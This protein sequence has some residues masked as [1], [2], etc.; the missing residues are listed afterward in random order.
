MDLLECLHEMAAVLFFFFSLL[1]LILKSQQVRWKSG[2]VL[3]LSSEAL[4]CFHSG[5]FIE[6]S[7]HSRG[8]KWGS[9]FSREKYERI[10]EDILIPLQRSH[11]FPVEKHFS[12]F[13]WYIESNISSWS[14]S[15]PSMASSYHPMPGTLV[16]HF[17]PCSVYFDCF[18][19][20]FLERDRLIPTPAL[21]PQLFLLP[22][23]LYSLVFAS[24][25]TCYYLD[26]CRNISS[27]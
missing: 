23:M 24:L 22:R 6:L 13:L 16:L 3:D 15:H 11:H 21:G 17:L 20:S 8:E 1:W 10:Y 7:P 19:P 2:C 25:A 27:S 18:W 4:H 14:N 9:T 12:S 5:L 26:L